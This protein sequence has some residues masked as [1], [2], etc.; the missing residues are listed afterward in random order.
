MGRFSLAQPA[1]PATPAPA[2]P[3]PGA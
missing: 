2:E 3:K 1:Q